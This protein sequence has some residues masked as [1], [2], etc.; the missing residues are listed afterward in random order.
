[1]RSHT[2]MHSTSHLRRDNTNTTVHQD[3]ISSDCKSHA[4]QDKICTVKNKNKEDIY[5][6]TRSQLLLHRYSIIVCFR[7]RPIGSRGLRVTENS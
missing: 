6:T 3:K 4:T 2:V 5:N 7:D 1:M